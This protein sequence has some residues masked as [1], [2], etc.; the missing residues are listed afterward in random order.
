KNIIRGLIRRGYSD[1]EVKK[2]AGGNV[3]QFFRRVMR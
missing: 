3:L 1:D 2:L